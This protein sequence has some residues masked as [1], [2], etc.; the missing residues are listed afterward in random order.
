M[1]TPCS[2]LRRFTVF[3]L[4]A[5]TFAG[6]ML[7]TQ[8]QLEPLA[9][10]EQEISK[11]ANGFVC[12]KQF[13][14][15]LSDEMFEDADALTAD[16]IQAFLEDTPWGKKSALAD[17]KNEAGDRASDMI[18]DAAEEFQ[19]NPIVLLA[20]LQ[21]EAGLIS[22]ETASESKLNA[23]LGCGC[24]DGKPCNAAYSGFGNQV[25]CSAQHSRAQY[26]RVATD[27]E[28]IAGWAPGKSKKTLDGYT[29]TPENAATASMYSY[30]PWV[31]PDTGGNYL[32]WYFL[33]KF[34]KELGY[35]APDAQDSTLSTVESLPPNANTEPTCSPPEDKVAKKLTCS[36]YGFKAGWPDTMCEAKG[37]GLC[38]GSGA[39]TADCDHCCEKCVYDVDCPSGQVCA[40]QG[41][42]HCCRA[43]GSGEECFTEQEC[44]AGQVCAWNGEGFYCM[45]PS[46]G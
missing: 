27:G 11:R 5:T 15:V 46:C 1:R 35:T 7:E 23:A 45:A 3:G 19:V 6:C 30:T 13:N 10:I 34:S 32:N 39:K 42:Y 40:W 26:D 31:L 8:G 36:Q 4:A 44:G 24:P 20:R 41:A 22:K 12:K 28:T 2:W 33:Q 43:P 21:T 38:K 29:V 37:N 9:Q 14:N 16:E 25:R 18:A 17:Y